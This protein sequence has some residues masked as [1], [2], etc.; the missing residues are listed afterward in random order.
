M[1]CLGSAITRANSAHASAASIR[2]NGGGSATLTNRG[3]ISV[4]PTPGGGA[5]FVV[6]MRGV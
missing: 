4:E 3:A 6:R 1:T 2:V 5:T